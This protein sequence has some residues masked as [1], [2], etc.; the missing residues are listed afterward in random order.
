LGGLYGQQ[1]GLANQGY[2]NRP[3]SQPSPWWQIGMA[4]L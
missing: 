1:Y 3:A 4:L 2:A